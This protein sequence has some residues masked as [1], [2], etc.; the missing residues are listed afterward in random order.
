MKIGPKGRSRREKLPKKREGWVEGEYG[1]GEIV[2]R[3]G[4]RQ[5]AIREGKAKH[6]HRQDT[7]GFV[8]MVVI[9]REAVSAASLPMQ[10]RRRRPIR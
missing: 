10:Q 2:D 7:Q 1:L 6:R 5:G 4:K 9:G 3:G 8:S